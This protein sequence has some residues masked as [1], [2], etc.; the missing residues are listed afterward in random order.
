MSVPDQL[1]S[2]Q[3]SLAE[4][5]RSTGRCEG[6]IDLLVDQLK[7]QDDRTTALTL[8]TDNRMTKLEGRTG[9]IENKQHWYSGAAGMLGGL[10]GA[11]G[12]HFRGSL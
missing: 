10:L 4:L 11:L 8:H 9:K 6:K 3:L 12:E 7:V 5:H 2:I 1:A